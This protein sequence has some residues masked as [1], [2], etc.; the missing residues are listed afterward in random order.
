MSAAA[1]RSDQRVISYFTVRLTSVLTCP[2]STGV[3]F[4]VGRL[5]AG[6]WREADAGRPVRRSRRSRAGGHRYS[7]PTWRI[8]AAC[9]RRLFERRLARLRARSAVVFEREVRPADIGRPGRDQR[10]EHLARP[11][12]IAQDDADPVGSLVAA[13]DLAL[14]LLVV[15]V[16]RVEADAGGLD[17]VRR[18]AERLDALRSPCPSQPAFC[19][20]ASTAV[21]RLGGHAGADIDDIGLGLDRLR[22]GQL[23]HRVLRRDLDFGG[24]SGRRRSEAAAINGRAKRFIWVSF[25]RR[26]ALP[27]LRA[28]EPACSSPAPAPKWRASWRNPRS[29]PGKASACSRAAAGC[30]AR[31]RPAVSTCMSARATGWR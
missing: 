22:H 23:D 11:V 10:I 7:R 18:D 2:G 19:R 3:V 5:Q 29:S 24:S 14:A 27:A 30:S 28:G 17:V 26:L 12:D 31:P 15:I 6:L 13:E 9:E 25:G 20:M 1:G 4:A 21:W 8:R 16:L